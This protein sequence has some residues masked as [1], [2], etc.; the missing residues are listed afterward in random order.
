[1]GWTPAQTLAMSEW[2]FAVSVD[3]FMRMNGAEAKPAPPT[4][5]EH[6]ALVARF[7]HLD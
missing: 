1:M 4:D 5:E 7:A 6:D 3:G 2:D